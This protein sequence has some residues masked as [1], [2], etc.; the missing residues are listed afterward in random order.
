MQL[1]PLNQVTVSVS[2]LLVTDDAADSIPMCCIMN[3]VTAEWTG[4]RHRLDTTI[5]REARKEAW[6]PAWGT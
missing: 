2:D 1:T 5:A 6:L 4:I 3:F